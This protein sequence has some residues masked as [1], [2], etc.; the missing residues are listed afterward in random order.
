MRTRSTSVY[1]AQSALKEFPLERTPA[2]AKEYFVDTKVALPLQRIHSGQKRPK[3][4]RRRERFDCSGWNAAAGE[5][6]WPNATW[7][8]SDFVFVSLMYFCV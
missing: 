4:C 2:D 3:K 7:R 1:G 8:D 5:G 6:Q